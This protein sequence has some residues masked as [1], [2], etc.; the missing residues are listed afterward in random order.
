MKKIFV[1]TVL[2]LLFAGCSNSDDELISR[3]EGDVQPGKEVAYLTRV[4]KTEGDYSLNNEIVPGVKRNEEGIQ[5]NAMP[6]DLER[7]YILSTD[8]EGVYLSR[9]SRGYVNIVGEYKV[10]EKAYH[11]PEM[12]PY[13]GYIQKFNIHPAGDSGYIQN[14]GIEYG[15]HEGHLQGLGGVWEGSRGYLE[16]VGGYD[17]TKEGYI[18]VFGGEEDIL[19][20]GYL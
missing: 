16:E 7:D 6:V 13:D 18:E 1:I 8:Q 3:W 12:V 20:N 5:V 19:Y 10:S 4:T 2:A 17:S 15:R 14:L 9:T 11:V